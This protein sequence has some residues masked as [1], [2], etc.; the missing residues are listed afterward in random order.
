MPNG[1]GRI[2]VTGLRAPEYRIW[3]AGESEG[4]PPEPLDKFRQDFIDV[5]V[6]AWVLPVGE[7]SQSR[8]K[9][10]DTKRAIAGLLACDT[11][12]RRW[13]EARDMKWQL[14]R[15]TQEWSP[16]M[17]RVMNGLSRRSEP[18]KRRFDK[19]L[20]GWMKEFGALDLGGP[21]KPDRVDDI[22]KMTHALRAWAIRDLSMPDRVWSRST[23]MLRVD[24]YERKVNEAAG[25]CERN[26]ETG[27]WTAP[28]LWSAM[29]HSIQHA[30]DYGWT[31]AECAAD[32][33]SNVFLKKRTEHATC[34]PRCGK[35][36]RDHQKKQS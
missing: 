35:R 1:K 26:R 36:M 11:D 8:E 12:F 21:K 14:A 28:T 22:M 3:R 27:E 6:V 4:E 31:F 25:E 32:D 2:R 33:C 19:H 20:M 30:R 16:R 18:S 13:V 9:A 5:G 24:K 10:V 15:T 23:F 17:K 34:S 29:C 7:A